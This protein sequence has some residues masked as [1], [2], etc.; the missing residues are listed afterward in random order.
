MNPMAGSVSSSN[1]LKMSS[2]RRKIASLQTESSVEEL[3]GADGEEGDVE[4]GGHGMHKKRAKK[5][6]VPLVGHV[7][8]TPSHPPLTT[9]NSSPFTSF[10]TQIGSTFRTRYPLPPLTTPI[11]PSLLTPLS[12]PPFL[13]PDWIHFPHP[14]HRRKCIHGLHR[15]HPLGQRAPLPHPATL[16][17]LDFASATRIAVGQARIGQTK[18]GRER[19]SLPHLN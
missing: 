2:F 8:S 9:P 15:A 12:S 7:L 19:W 5:K 17:S 6:G 14:L 4:G 13:T 18:C 3:D 16:L 11:T 10:S 1:N